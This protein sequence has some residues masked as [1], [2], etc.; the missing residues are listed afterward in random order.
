MFCAILKF[1]GE[2]RRWGDREVE[3]GRELNI[4]Q[5]LTNIEVRSKYLLHKSHI[6]VPCSE[7]DLQ[8]AN[9]NNINKEKGL[10]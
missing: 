5:G 8:F 1:E 2:K 7:I 10:Q 6:S 4:E 3:M 9:K